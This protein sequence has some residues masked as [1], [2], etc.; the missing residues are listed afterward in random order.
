V[1]DKERANAA[2]A[3]IRAIRKNQ[4]AMV[5]KRIAIG[6]PRGSDAVS[7]TY[8]DGTPVMLVAFWN[9]YGVTFEHPG[10][11]RY[12]V[13]G[14]GKA[15][16]VSNDFVGPVAGVTQPHTITIPRR[17]FMQS[18][19][20]KAYDI[21]KPFVEQA[22]PFINDGSLDAAPLLEQIGAKA[23]AI[24]AQEA[25]NLRAPPN[26]PS[27]VRMKGSSNPLVSSGLMTQSITYEVR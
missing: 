23:A 12:V 4:R 9:N 7:L 6:W 3:K 27:T 13:G 18:G 24:V 15:R 16:F 2:A 8:P 25:T 20:R 17:E 1:N 21:I 11:T 26:A 10:G 22:M 5:R 19:T 14:D